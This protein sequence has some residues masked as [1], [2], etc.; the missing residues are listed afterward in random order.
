MVYLQTINKSLLLSLSKYF[1]NSLLSVFH[2]LNSNPASDIISFVPETS[3]NF[4]LSELY[5]I[6]FKVVAIVKM[7]FKRNGHLV[8]P[9]TTNKYLL[10]VF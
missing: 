6:T 5:K 8:K 7:V 4:Q 10:P 2:F 9:T 3:R 1:F